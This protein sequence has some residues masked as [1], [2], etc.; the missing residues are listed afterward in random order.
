MGRSATGVR[1]LKVSGD[2]EVVGMEILTPGATILTVTEKGY[3]KR[4][5]LDAYRIQNRGGQGIIT[6]K[7]TE[8]NGPVVGVA[9]VV[10]EDQLMLITN[11]G[12]VLRCAATGISVMGRNTQG[13]R[14]MDLASDETLVSIARLAEGD[15]ARVAAGDNA[16]EPASQPEPEAATE[17]PEE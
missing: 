7:T 10:D 12:K 4:T 9:Q 2:D 15:E 8:R 16:V 14:I 6:I 5:P 1:G 17:E 13:V 3:G 11:G